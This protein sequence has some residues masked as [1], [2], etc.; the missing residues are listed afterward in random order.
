MILQKKNWENPGKKLIL[1]SSNDTADLARDLAKQLKPGDVVAFY[2][3][4]GSGKTFMIKHICHSLK[5][6]E[7]PTSPSFTLINEYHTSQ[8]INIYHFDFYR[9]EYET[10]LTNL[11][12]DD[13]LFNEH[14]CL[15]E[16]ADKIQ[17]FLP[18]KRY[19]IFIKFIE[20]RPESREIE[21]IQQDQH[22]K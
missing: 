18:Q 16:W 19:D 17:K 7:E 10:E 14:I 20:Q 9:L 2:G 22:G 15:I 11:G 1:N 13:L 8:Q 3:D 21:I 4:L 6:I 5:T 12:I